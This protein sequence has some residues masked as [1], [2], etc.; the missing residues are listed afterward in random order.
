MENFEEDITNESFW[1]E[2][3]TDCS[4]EAEHIVEI[5]NDY[6]VNEVVLNRETFFPSDIMA[7]LEERFTCYSMT[8]HLAAVKLLINLEYT[9]MLMYY[10]VVMDSLFIN[11]EIENKEQL[12]ETLTPEQ[13]IREKDTIKDKV[14]EF[15]IEI[16]KNKL[17]RIGKIFNYLRDREFRVLSNTFY[18][19]GSDF[20]LFL[21]LKSIVG[22]NL[23][24]K[25][26]YHCDSPEDAAI[27][28]ERFRDLQNK[29]K[30]IGEENE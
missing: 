3:A 12:N 30:A 4:D 28:L 6:P 1:D 23:R 18:M 11:S 19:D 5:E 27:L 10:C 20:I 29:Y 26:V 21:S 15:N 13:F 9:D 2:L 16:P 8:E 17:T 24:I 7:E 22:Y 25:I 14:F